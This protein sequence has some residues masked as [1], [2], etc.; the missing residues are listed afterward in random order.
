MYV[1]L[2]RFVKIYVKYMCDGGP[3]GH[4]YID[5]GYMHKCSRLKYW[6]LDHRG[7]FMHM[8]AY[9]YI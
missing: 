9:V 5:I 8:Y 7:T 4:R 6:C 2:Y 3:Y 1:L